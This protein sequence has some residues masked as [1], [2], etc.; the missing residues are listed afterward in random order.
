M[1][2]YRSKAL[3][4]LKQYNN[5]IC[6]EAVP[7]PRKDDPD[8]IGKKPI[9]PVT[10]KLAS[11]TDPAT[12]T[13]YNTAVQASKYY[14]GIGFVFTSTPYFGIDLDKIDEDLNAY[15]KGDTNN[16][17]T[18]FISSLQSY[19]ELSQSGKGIHIICKGTLPA[20]GRRCGNVEMYETGRYFTMSGKCIA[21]Y[22]INDCTESIKPLHKKYIGAEPSAPSPMLSYT[23]ISVDVQDRLDKLR[24][25]RQG[26]LF[27]ALMA[28]DI[29]GYTSNSEADLALCNILAFWLGCDAELID[30]VYR[31]SGLMRDKWDR[32]QSGSTYGKLTVQKAISSCTN[33]YTASRQTADSDGYSLTIGAASKKDSDT[34]KLYT[35]DDTGNAERIYDNFG[36]RLL[37]NFNDKSWYYWDKT[38][39]H[40]DDT[41]TIKR[42]ADASLDIMASETEEYVKQ[43]LINSGGEVKLDNTGT[44]KDGELTKAFK[45]HIKTSRSSKSKNAMITE[46]QHKLPALPGTFDKHPYLFNTPSCTVDLK[47]GKLLEHDKTKYITK[48]AGTTVSDT[49]KAPIWCNFLDTVFCGDKELVRY[50]QKAV[51]Y[52]LSGSIAE[53]CMFFL[54]GNGHN[55]KSTFLELLR[56]L[57]G[58]YCV[59]AQIESF[60]ISH[61]T[62]SNATSDIARLKGARLVTASEPNEGVRLDEGLIKQL[63]GG[64]VVTARYQ[65]ASEFEYTPEFKIWIAANHRPIIRGT[66]IGIWRRIHVIPFNANIPETKKDLRLPQKLKTELPAILRWA[67]NGYTLYSKEG[68]RKPAAVMAAVQCYKREMD[69]ISAFIDACCIIGDGSVPSSYLYSTYKSWAENNNEYAMSHT[70]FTAELSKRDGI[71]RARVRDGTEFKGITLKNSYDDFD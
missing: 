45:K 39:W 18:E 36:D 34:V 13:D 58:D 60:I 61:R 12:W 69:V 46:L 66:D 55:G 53:Q 32:R 59:N 2:I 24:K 19:A 71:T 15:D 50:V 47:S 41:G 10:G 68:L 70:K 52:S 35:L 8:H 57:M 28:G 38:R 33:V 14:G 22:P 56:A 31:T 48:M 1:T 6:W 30:N 4:E 20:G 27:D 37:Y 65:Y 51:G 5:W 29:T 43:D 17:V 54:H 42:I 64:D 62:G 49:A 21:D 16:I 25:S 67:I 7:Q 40:K 23:P 3:D 63:T 11:S 9:N 44:P 26:A